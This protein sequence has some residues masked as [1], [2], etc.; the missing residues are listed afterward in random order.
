V[1]T[2]RKIANETVLRLVASAPNVIGVKDASG[3]PSSTA[4]LL[5]TAPASLEI[6]SGDDS[7]T[8]ALLA[9]GAVGAVSVASHYA[10]PEI[11]E[12][13][14]LFLAGDVERAASLNAE[15][16]AAVDFQSSEEAPNPLPAKAVL[17]AMGLKVGQCRLPHG[18][19]PDWLDSRAEDLVLGLE[20]L[21]QARRGG[22]ASG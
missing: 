15:L 13:I 14:R 17:R 4:R 1:R 12:M 21:R 11:A 6:Y 3:D 10:G 22:R 2:G 8:L 16:V 18:E 19:A 20:A 9:I 5:A 7:L